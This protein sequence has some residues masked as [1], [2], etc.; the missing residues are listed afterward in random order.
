MSTMF[1]YYLI[2]FLGGAELSSLAHSSAIQAK[3]AVES[4]HT[5]G[6]QAAYGVKNSLAQQAAAVSDY[7]VYIVHLEHSE[8]T[9][10]AW[11]SLNVYNYFYL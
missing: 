2:L 10:M 11:C 5:A 7:H 8:I 4:Q 6:S 1:I 9:N 3:T